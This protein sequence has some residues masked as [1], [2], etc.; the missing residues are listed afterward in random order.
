LYEQSNQ[1]YDYM[2]FSVN[3]AKNSNELLSVF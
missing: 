2:Y 3:Y 1:N